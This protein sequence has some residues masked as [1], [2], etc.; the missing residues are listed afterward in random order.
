[1][2]TTRNWE[3]TPEEAVRIAAARLESDARMRRRRLREH[4]ETLA[5]HLRAIVERQEAF[6]DAN[7][8]GEQA[9]FQRAA[10]AFHDSI[11]GAA[12]FLRSIGEQVEGGA[13]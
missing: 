8:R 10:D 3:P 5:G 6:F 2:E 4:A 11:D 12:D 1:M 9:A 7:D 13:A